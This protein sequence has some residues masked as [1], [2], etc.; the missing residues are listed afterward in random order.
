MCGEEHTRKVEKYWEKIWGIIKETLG[1]TQDWLCIPAESD[2][3][4][5]TGW[6]QI[7]D[8]DTAASQQENYN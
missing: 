6:G 7:P 8:Q 5:H 4:K 2:T 1:D 3:G